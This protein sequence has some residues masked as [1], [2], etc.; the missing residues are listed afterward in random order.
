M[1]PSIFRFVYVHTRKQ[2]LYITILTLVSF[3]FLYYSLDLPKTIINKAIQGT[4][5]PQTL[6]GFELDQL[7]YLLALSGI[8]LLLVLINGA[9]KY[10]IN[11]YK[12][13]LG[14]RMLRR[15]RYELYD[16][17]LHFPLR[18]FTRVPPGQIIPIITSEVEPLGGFVGEC[19][20]TPVF[21]GGTL[22]TIL[23]F[24]AVQDPWLGLAAVALY[25]AQAYFIPRLQRRVN[26]LSKQRI[27]LVRTLSDVINESAVGLEE[28]QTH[29]ILPY[30][31]AQFSARLGTNY[32]IRFR[33][34]LLKFL[35]KFL[36][37]FIAQLTPF[38]FYAIGGYLVITGQLT[39]GALVA[40]LA[41]YKDLGPPWR[42]LLDFYQQKED[43]RIKYEQVIEQFAPPGLR[44]DAE[45]DAAAAEIRQ[46]DELR[47]EGVTIV[48]EDGYTHADGVSLQLGAGERVALVGD[49]RSGK[50]EVA[51]ALGGLLV[52]K[53][54]RVLIGGHDLFSLPRS[55][56]SRHVGYVGPSSH[57]FA[58]SIFDNLVFGLRT[59]PRP[60]E[61][62]S[63]ELG[64]HRKEA[65]LTGNSADDPDADWIDY[66]RAGV[67][68]RAELLGRIFELLEITELFD[69]L[70]ELGLRGVVDPDGHPEIVETVLAARAVLHEHFLDPAL[71][72]F[73][74]AFDP[75]GFNEQLSLGENLLFGQPVGPA[76]DLEH[77]GENDYVRRILAERRLGDRLIGLG[78]EITRTI[79]M[80]F[81]DL[82]TGHELFRKFSFI[83]ADELPA[84]E[85]VLAR[86]GE[87]LPE[88]LSSDERQLLVS[89]VFRMVPARHR[90]AIEDPALRDD[91]LAARR[92][93]A[94]DLP[95]DLQGAIEFYR[96]E[97]YT[98]NASLQDN[99]LFGRL[100]QGQN[101][102]G[103][104]AR[105]IV[106]EALERADLLKRV[107]EVCID[108]GLE[109]QAGAGGARLSPA[110]RQ[111]LAIARALLKRPDVLVLSDAGSQL[112]PDSYSRILGRIL[113]RGE[114]GMLICATHPAGPLHHFDRVLE[115]E[116]G[117]IREREAESGVG[118]PVPGVSAAD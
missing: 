44:S 30:Q 39:A 17:M 112:D 55:I 38:F 88:R 32:S 43:A 90:L 56:A 70:R 46:I 99:L 40:V 31:L 72:G 28:I 20:A 103:S 52:P 77:L 10:Y 7:P 60:G 50:S 98:R 16:R 97:S 18:Y 41:A 25:P 37:N 85:G 65:L 8:F 76:F 54:G 5:F 24:M 12:G 19:F 36:N 68:D 11:V 84:L 93:F 33:I 109:F 83:S 86:K 115:I 15:L 75:D 13:R 92:R 35:I 61:A 9:F 108:V 21:Q 91:I 78:V 80:L 104:R 3:P 53:S 113:E 4:K 96:P 51:L 64:D 42:E 26:Q 79:S 101:Q 111:K 110:M 106:A 6:F 105:T 87:I 116:G 23:F 73:F 62:P 102:V 117:R 89:L 114:T 107:R 95:A 100:A 74:E 66:A 49:D 34:Y 27:R 71:H 57:L 1:E 47:V 118:E 69:D 29:A 94:E 67:A 82:S 48:D 22:L 59:S 58:A 2:Q 45:L 63:S 81:R 14:E